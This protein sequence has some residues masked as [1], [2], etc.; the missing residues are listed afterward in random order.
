MCS[1]YWL[2]GGCAFNAICSPSISGEPVCS[3]EL[4]EDLLT[5]DPDTYG[6]KYSRATFV[7]TVPSILLAAYA[8]VLLVQTVRFILRERRKRVFAIDLMGLSLL[9]HCSSAFWSILFILDSVG[10]AHATN[11]T[12]WNF[13][14]GRLS[15]VLIALTGFSC[16][17]GIIFFIASLGSLM[18]AISISLKKLGSRRY[19]RRERDRVLLSVGSGTFYVLAVLI[20]RAAL[21]APASGIVSA[22][23]TLVIMVILHV[24]FKRVTKPLRESESAAM[25]VTKK[26]LD[27]LER[28]AVTLQWALFFLT[29]VTLSQ[30][31]AYFIGR[32]FVSKPL[33]AETRGVALL[34]VRAALIY[35][36]HMTVHASRTIYGLQLMIIS[37]G[38]NHKTTLLRLIQGGGSTGDSSSVANSN[39]PINSPIG[40]PIKSLTS[41]MNSQTSCPPD[42]P[43]VGPET[44][45]ISPTILRPSD[46]DS[47]VNTKDLDPLKHQDTLEDSMLTVV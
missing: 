11:E 32:L 47:T 39:S 9:V 20:L 26:F 24:F 14:S 6:C 34:L 4:S 2:S 8:M 10:K 38:Q 21:G 36:L 40:S 29:I 41:T 46:L 44:R 43:T 5:F 12:L 25:G 28:L 30:S 27:M 31:M 35:L 19:I 22:I 3:C 7:L 15:D 17:F 37:G 1:P 16:I 23:T 13:F 18:S 33:L 42:A 45:R